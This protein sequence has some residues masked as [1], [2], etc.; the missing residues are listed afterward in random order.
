MIDLEDIRAFVEVAETGGFARA[1]RTLN[2]STS[3]ISRRLDRLEA[4][5]G[6]RLFTRT[7]RGVAMTE[8]GINFRPYADKV[9][10]D[11][12]AARDA[13][14]QQGDEITGAL[15][16]AAPLSFGTMHLA[17]VL[18]ELAIR[19]PRLAIDTDYSD[20][21]VNL[22]AERFDVA[23]RVGSLPDSSLI[24][25]K[26]APIHAALVAS[27]AYLARTGEPKTV[28]DLETHEAVVQQGAAWR[29][30]GAGMG[31][32]SARMQVRFRANSGE[33]VAMAAEAGLG[34]AA[35][36]TFLTG[37]AIAEGRLVK[38]LPDAKFPDLGLYVV[39]AP[40]A[41][42]TPAKIRALTD[43]MLEKFGGEPWW[44]VMCTGE[45]R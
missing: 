9:L 18:A 28:K 37:Q 30:G 38:I 33:A 27:P 29:F 25:C 8:S 43:L 34:I 35:L 45:R 44:D 40:P 3:M 39:R 36:P 42:H 26:I 12:E 24:A 17:P 21:M 15:R 19:H 7:T 16:I 1:G 20:R 32:I 4:E 6:A 14:S 22:V 11:L 2:L 5:L 41:G 13:V 23:I 31:D 10:A